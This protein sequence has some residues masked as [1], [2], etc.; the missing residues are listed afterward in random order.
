MRLTLVNLSRFNHACH[1]DY[2]LRDHYAHHRK[3]CSQVRHP[4]GSSYSP[5]LLFVQ[6]LM[7]T[8]TSKNASKSPES[9]RETYIR[10]LPNSKDKKKHPKKENPKGK[11]KQR[12]KK[13][14]EKKRR[15]RETPRTGST[16][17]LKIYTAKLL[18]QNRNV[19]EDILT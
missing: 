2:V 7:A 12:R 17:F 1:D 10:N 13:D 11:T 15:A 16:E 3:T 6:P 18:W 5:R 4:T 19:T 8:P 9:R 14:Q